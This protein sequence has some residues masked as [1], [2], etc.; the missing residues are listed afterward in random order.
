[1]MGG[2][3]VAAAVAIPVVVLLGIGV[4]MVGA[5]VI[6]FVIT[7]HNLLEKSL[8]CIEVEHLHIQFMIVRIIVITPTVA[9]IIVL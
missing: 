3:N 2:V 7:Q 1:M 4:V 6:V 8:F 5:V 9:V